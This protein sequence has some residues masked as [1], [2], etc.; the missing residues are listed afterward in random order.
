MADFDG[1]PTQTND[2]AGGTGI[3]QDQ[4]WRL[5]DILDGIRVNGMVSFEADAEA[6]AILNE[7]DGEDRQPAD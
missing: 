7:I 5:F 3:T 6:C 1:I 4:A 2:D